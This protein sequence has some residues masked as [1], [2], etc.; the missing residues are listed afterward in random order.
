MLSIGWTNS[1]DISLHIPKRLETR[2]SAP[3]KI[4]YSF[5]LKV[6]Y[7]RQEH[8]QSW[9]PNSSHESNHEI[10]THPWLVEHTMPKTYK[11]CGNLVRQ[12]FFWFPSHHH[13]PLLGCDLERQSQHFFKHSRH[14]P[15]AWKKLWRFGG[16]LCCSHFAHTQSLWN[17]CPTKHV[18]VQL[19]PN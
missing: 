14:L 2:L 4:G 5:N 7:W 6:F 8:H 16:G 3:N 11:V 12:F 10:A 15:P 19:M 17:E 13:L 9:N 18:I 1:L